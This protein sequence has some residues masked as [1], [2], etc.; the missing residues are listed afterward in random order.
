MTEEP[1]RAAPGSSRRS[2]ARTAATRRS[3]HGDFLRRLALRRVPARV[4]PPPDRHGGDGMTIALRR[5]TPHWLA[6]AADA[7]FDGI[8]D[9]VEQ[10]LAVLRWAG[11]TFGDELRHH[12]VDGRRPARAPGQHRRSPAST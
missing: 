8:E 1:T 4:Q 3:P 11:D 10:A 6:D 2:T 9:P 7:W 5:P 12:L